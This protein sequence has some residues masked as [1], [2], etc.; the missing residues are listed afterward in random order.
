LDHEKLKG[1]EEDDYNE[2]F[3]EKMRKIINELKTKEEENSFIVI[4]KTTQETFLEL[5]S[6]REK[7]ESIKF[8]K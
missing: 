1:K 4:V 5:S 7:D 8:I 6:S 2:S 3:F